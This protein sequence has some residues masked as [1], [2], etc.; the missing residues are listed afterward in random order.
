MSPPMTRMPY[1][2]KSIDRQLSQQIKTYL[3]NDIVFEYVQEKNLLI[4]PLVF[5]SHA[6]FFQKHYTNNKRFRAYEPTV[7]SAF[8]FIYEYANPVDQ[9]LLE[10][11]STDTEIKFKRRRW[12]YYMKLNESE[13]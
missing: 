6:D 12:R 4:I 11:I 1:Y 8:N 13:K 2:G 10:K 3:S 9:L 5:E 7:H